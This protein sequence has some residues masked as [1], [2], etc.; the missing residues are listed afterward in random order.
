MKR[1][2]NYINGFGKTLVW[3]GIVDLSCF[4]SITQKIPT[5]NIHC[6]PIKRKKTGGNFEPF[7]AII[8]GEETQ[9]NYNLYET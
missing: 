2:N 8:I 4:T 9:W 1:G 3:G 5:T 6:G 7:S